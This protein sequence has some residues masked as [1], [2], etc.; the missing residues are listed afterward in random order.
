MESPYNNCAWFLG[1][2]DQSRTWFQFTLRDSF[3]LQRLPLKR[4][5]NKQYKLHSALCVIYHRALNWPWKTGG[6]GWHI[7]MVG[8]LC[9]KRHNWLKLLEEGGGNKRRNWRKR[10]TGMWEGL[11]TVLKLDLHYFCK[12]ESFSRTCP[13]WERASLHLVLVII[14]QSSHG[15]QDHRLRSSM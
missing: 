5:H 1:P 14:I 9:S 4:N 3:G 8:E 12:Q 2:R 10:G 6:C 7:W 15:Q 11:Q 13:V